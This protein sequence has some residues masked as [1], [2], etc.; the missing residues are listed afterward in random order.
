MHQSQN[1]SEPAGEEDGFSDDDGVALAAGGDHA[2]FYLQEIADEAEIVY[3]GL[4]QLRGF[5]Y[6]VSILTPAGESLVFGN[7][8]FVLFGEGGHFVNGLAFVLVACADLDFALGVE[9][10]ELGDDQRV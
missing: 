9:D 6:A 2:Y 4:G 10:V 5:L 7:D 3:G 1:L 8:V